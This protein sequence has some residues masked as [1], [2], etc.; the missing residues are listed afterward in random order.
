M[1][2]IEIYAALPHLS[3]QPA[4]EPC[5]RT[6]PTGGFDGQRRNGEKQTQIELE[7]IRL[8]RFRIPIIFLCASFH[9]RSFR[10]LSHV[11]KN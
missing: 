7:V 9:P 5:L 6:A 4:V 10:R 11:I 2:L 8:I 3:R 1:T